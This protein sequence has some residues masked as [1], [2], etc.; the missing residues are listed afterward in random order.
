[1]LNLDALL[2]AKASIETS[3]GTIFVRHAHSSDWKYLELDDPIELARV[4]VQRLCSRVEDKRD[5][6]PLVDDDLNVLTDSDY[7]ALVPAIAKQC[8]WQNL[9]DGSG[10]KELGTVIMEEKQLMSERHEKM[11]GEMRKSI[12]SS[13]SFLGKGVLEKLQG[14]MAGI[15]DIRKTL[16]GADSIQAVLRAAT[17]PEESWRKSLAEIDTVGK[18]MRD[19]NTQN[20][21]TQVELPRTYDAPKIMMPPRFEETPMGRATLESV[22]NSRQVAEKMDA[23][24]VVVAG[25]NQT[26][27]Q[28]VLPAWFKKI[29]EDQQAAK[30]SAGQAARSLQWTKWAVIASVFVT[31]AATWWQV[32]VAKTIDRENSE[33]QKRVEALLREQLGA[34][35]KLI[36]QQAKDAAAMQEAVMTLRQTTSAVKVKNR[37]G[38]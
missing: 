25:L 18:V 26:M 1:M 7:Q 21:A 37:Q 33:Q 10:L 14:Q 38:E 30:K 36:A 29:G 11:L 17:L 9:P 27:V 24:V 32:D 28:D 35:Q 13:Y 16:A 6:S 8:G 20:V 23:L 15:A 31:I 3:V 5:S 19:L 34:Q 4:S 22:E 2:P 12:E